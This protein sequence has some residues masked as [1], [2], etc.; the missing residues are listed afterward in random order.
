MVYPSE[1][2]LP[3]RSFC[4]NVLEKLKTRNAD[5]A[6]RLLFQFWSFV[7]SRYPRD[8]SLFNNLLFSSLHSSPTASE[9][10]L[11]D[12]YISAV[13]QLRGLKL[14]ELAATSLG[15]HFPALLEH[16]FQSGPFETEGSLLSVQEVASIIDDFPNQDSESRLETIKTLLTKFSPKEHKWFCLLLMKKCEFRCEEKDLYQIWMK[17]QQRNIV[18]SVFL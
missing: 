1:N 7:Q 17:F 9:H 8:F 2:G 14:I 16:L 18:D 5:E 10:Q 3:F 6:S 12:S 13:P 4:H 15:I 11:F